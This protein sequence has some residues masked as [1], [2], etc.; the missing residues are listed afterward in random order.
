MAALLCIFSYY[1]NMIYVGMLV[2]I[3]HDVS[4]AFLILARSYT[5]YKYKNL[6]VNILL[7]VFMVTSWIYMRNIVFN[8]CPIKSCFMFYSKMQDHY[9]SDVVLTPIIF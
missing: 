1:M 4:D 2:L 5:D 8:I 7:G 6:P 3:V 9:L